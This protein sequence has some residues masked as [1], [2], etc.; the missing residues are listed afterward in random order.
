MNGQDSEGRHALSG[1]DH[2][3]ALVVI[4]AY[5]EES[6]ISS[7]VTEVLGYF[8]NVVV[9]DDGSTDETGKRA[10]EA[11]ATVIR[12]AVNLGQG[13]ALETG[14]TFGLQRRD[15]Q[16]FVTFDA[17]GQHRPEDAVRLVRRLEASG[18]HLVLGTRFHGDAARLIPPIRRMVL[19]AARW[20]SRRSSGLSLTDA[21]NGLRAFGRTA[22]AEFRFTHPGMAHASEIT[23]IAAARGFS[24]I[25]EPVTIRYTDYSL[26]KGQSLLNAINISFDLFW[27]R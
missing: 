14:I 6:V 9:V 5:N 25:E 10:R 3:N 26:Q 8:R 13:A 23:N 4:A 19:R 27:R 17:D 18:A 22:A 21:H 24:V 12:H 7:V 20:Y 2:I 15:I 11:G 16:K 1:S